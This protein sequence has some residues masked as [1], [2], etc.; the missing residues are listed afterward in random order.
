MTRNRLFDPDM[1]LPRALTSEP[2]KPEAPRAAQTAPERA[3]AQAEQRPLG[4][5]EH[6][7]ATQAAPVIGPENSREGS[8]TPRDDL[9]IGT[10]HVLGDVLDGG[11]G[12]DVILAGD[13]NDTISGGAGDDYVFGQ[14]GDDTLVYD[15]V[16]NAGDEDFYTGGLGFDR[17]VLNVTDATTNSAAFQAEVAAFLAFI[18]ANMIVSPFLANGQRFTFETL[19]LTVSR[20]EEVVVNGEDP[21]ELPGSGT[22]GFVLRGLAEGAGF[23]NAIGSAGDLNGDGIADIVIGSTWA[24]GTY[25]DIGASASGMTYVVFGQDAAADGPM[26]PLVDLAAFDGTNGFVTLGEVGTGLGLAVGSAGDINGDGIDD[27]LFASKYDAYILF[28]RDE[29]AGLGFDVIEDHLALDGTDGFAISLSNKPAGTVTTGDVNG[30]GIDDVMVGLDDDAYVIFGRDTATDGDFDASYSEGDLT[31]D[32][33]L[34]ISDSAIY[35]SVIVGDVNGDGIDDMLLAGADVPPAGEDGGESLANAHVVFGKDTEADGDFSDRINLDRLS[36]ED[37]FS[38]TSPLYGELSLSVTPAAPGDVNGDGI[39]DMMIGAISPDGQPGHVYVLF[40]K[41]TAVQGAFDADIDL[42][43]LDGTNGFIMEGPSDG[44]TYT[45][46][47]TSSA[48]DVNGDGIDDML[49]GYEYDIGIG[50]DS[51]T[52]L[53]F[54]RDTDAEGAFDPT[55]D[56]T[57]LDGSD[58]FIFLGDRPSDGAGAAVA[59]AGDLNGDGIDDLLISAPGA[60]ALEGETY[61]IYGGATLDGFDAAD[62]LADGTIDLGLL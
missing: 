36:P 46:V 57:A 20:F 8:G 47:A 19:G 59:A 33:G 30:D 14:E 16:L 62:G 21:A 3:R 34:V 43:E 42:S 51:R 10:D 2:A 61:A 17:L 24:A 32:A 56:L 13:W 23:G 41:D 40:G 5:G 39:A 45:S 48:G 12:D 15:E 35:R 58:G 18:E 50:Y 29:A 37:G 27:L 9:I 31:G 22:Y 1:R 44:E 26:D 53:V 7:L 49:V 28:G 55:L 54:G 6:P 38:M 60:A 4:G 11:E 52:Y 25:P